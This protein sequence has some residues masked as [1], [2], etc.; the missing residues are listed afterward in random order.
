MLDGVLVTE[1]KKSKSDI[2]KEV[3]F[4][5][6]KAYMIGDTEEDIIAGK[7]NKIGTVAVLSG[8]AGEKDLAILQPDITLN[9][10]TELK[11]IELI[12]D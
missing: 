5:N 9:Y 10:V 8:F 3:L 7:E 4:L 2:I 12:N 1:R 11:L 6:E